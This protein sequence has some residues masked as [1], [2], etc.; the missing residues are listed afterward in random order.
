[1]TLWILS[2]VAG[3]GLAALG[4]GV[5]GAAAARV[6]AALRATVGVLATALLLDAPLGAERPARP[7]VGLDASQS[8]L[9]H[10]D[11]LRWH[12][13]LALADSVLGAGADSLL[14][15]GDSVR[16]GARPE[17]AADRASRVG[18]LVEA[19]LAVGRPVVLITDGVLDDP[20]R[21][22]RLP[23]GSHVLVPAGTAAAAAADLAVSAFDA[24]GGALG[25]DTIA[26]RVVVRAGGGG[27]DATSGRLTLDGRTVGT[28]AL[29]VLVPY[30]ERELR[31]DVPIPAQD[32]ARVLV[33]ALAGGDAVARNDSA[34]SELA[35]SGAAAAVFVSTS[36]DQDARFALAVLRGTRRGPVRAYW[37]VAPGQWR[38]DGTLRPVE[39]AVVRRAVASAPLA[40]FHGDTAVFGPPRG[41][42]R[43]ALVLV[44]PPPAGD[45]YYPTG[46]GDSPLVAALSGVPWDSLPPLDVAPLRSAPRYPAVLARRARRLEERVVV[47]LTEGPPRVAVVPASGMWRW[48][49]R[50]G[51]ASD[52]FDAVWGSIFDWVGAEPAREASLAGRAAAAGQ[53][54]APEWVPRRPNVAAGPVG[55]GAPLDLAPR[56]RGTWWIV[57]L[58]L[59][60]LCGEWLLRR[61]IGLR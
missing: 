61:R 55:D 53:G 38:V 27:A 19:A 18:P 60:A 7:W 46:T 29:A 22:A 59:L 36:P 49:L 35:V 12:A 21:V 45:E 11:T 8:W 30:E 48:R 28:R 31:F 54:I 13:A 23:R 17:R 39:E 58:A 9:A 16:G 6:P 56:A 4:Y 40:V 25:G 51:R 20:E 26:V 42:A 24:P 3:L 37:R 41:L 15:F 57:A 52:A 47:G 44:A 14:V 1:M 5:R 34:R 43:G 10:G 32:A 2:L 50:G 33:F